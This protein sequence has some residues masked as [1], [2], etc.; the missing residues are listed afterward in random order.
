MIAVV[1]TVFN[2]RKGVAEFLQS[3]R[4]QTLQPSE[5]II[6][7]GGSRD[8]T[9]ELLSE[10]SDA[11]GYGFQL[12]IHQETG[13]NVARGRDLAIE[14]AGCEL[15]VSTDIGCE[16]DSEWI[17][18]LSAPL[19]NDAGCDLVIGSWGVKRE[20]LEGPWAMTE[21]GLKGDQFLEATPDSYSSSRSIAYRRAAWESLGKYPQDLTLAAD[22]AVFHYLIEQAEVPRSS[23]PTIRCYWHRHKRLKSFLREASRYGLGDGEA[24]I[25]MKDHSLIAGRLLLEVIGLVGGGLGALFLVGW[26]RA[27][28]LVL[29]TVA[30]LSI[31][32]RI[33]RLQKARGALKREGIDWPMFRLLAFVYGTKFNSSVGYLKGLLRGG[34]AC[35]SCRQR[36]REMTPQLYSERRAAIVS[37]DRSP[38]SF[39]T[40]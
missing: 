19:R 27:V 17:E 8:G 18:E 15:I 32:A 3:M 5:V 16:W 29:L 39:A 35:R 14:M 38:N 9:W 22:D 25:R 10:A 37:G 2:D 34:T 26:P 21:W 40:S 12:K 1:T 20:G 28:C 13:C 23:A 31:V 30:V 24:A 33:A 11:Q 7:D 36:L 6:V 4:E